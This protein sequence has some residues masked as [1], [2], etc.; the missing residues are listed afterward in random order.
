MV[1]VSRPNGAAPASRCRSNREACLRLRSASSLRD[2]VGRVA[3]GLQPRW[4]ARRNER[5]ES[6]R[7]RSPLPHWGG[8]Q[9][10]AILRQSQE[11][12]V[13]PG[14]LAIERGRAIVAQGLSP[15][16]ASMKEASR[17]GPERQARLSPAGSICSKPR[18]LAPS[19]SFTSDL[20]RNAR[21]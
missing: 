11:S 1:L 15:S 16:A 19:Y 10:S 20:K 6:S 2:I 5:L 18:K 14:T 8:K 21:G 17:A 4:G 3:I 9:R 12:Q 7:G 13:S